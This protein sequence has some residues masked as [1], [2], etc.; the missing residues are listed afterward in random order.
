MSD[1]VKENLEKIHIM[2][3][4]QDVKDTSSG[5]AI[6]A[7]ALAALAEIEAKP[8]EFKPFD[9]ITCP[10]CFKSRAKTFPATKCECEQPNR[11]K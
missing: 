8:T 5:N 3:H 9:L 4:N 10:K 1:V 6:D 11:Q 7:C 2:A